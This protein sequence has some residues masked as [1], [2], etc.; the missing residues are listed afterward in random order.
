MDDASD[1]PTRSYLYELQK[2]EHI[3]LLKTSSFRL[4]V[5][6]TRKGFPGTVNRGLALA[7]GRYILLLNSDT[8]LPTRA[9]SNFKQ[10]FEADPMIGALGPVSNAASWQSVP[11]LLNTDGNFVINEIGSEWSVDMISALSEELS[12]ERSPEMWLLNGFCL[13]VPAEV[14]HTVGTL[15]ETAFG[16]G[17]GEEND[18]M[19]RTRA[20]GFRTVVDTHTYVYHQKTASYS[21]SESAQL[22]KQ[23][24]IVLRSMHTNAVVDAALKQVKA[25]R[26]LDILRIR[27]ASALQYVAPAQYFASEHPRILFVLP[28][29]TLGGGAVS[30]V[31]DCWQMNLLGHYCVVA[32]PVSSK[33]AWEPTLPGV[34]KH[35]LWGYQ[36]IDEAIPFGACNNMPVCKRPLLICLFSALYSQQLS[37]RSWYCL[38]LADHDPQNYTN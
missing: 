28:A 11:G 2:G 7:R 16:L 6:T 25:I 13:A 34:P 36:S 22:S 26:S 19:L 3:P 38:P 4:V 29:A 5:Q 35:M 8:V 30:V 37:R 9:L 33:L 10:L 27:L 23:A 32:L 14:I 31:S 18:L 24:S 12:Q 17:Y 20:A 21:K 15:N 1:P